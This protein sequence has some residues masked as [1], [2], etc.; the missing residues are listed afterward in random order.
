MISA[1]P[2]METKAALPV[3]PMPMEALR[4]TA[5]R[6]PLAILT[7]RLCPLTPGTYTLSGGAALPTGSRLVARNADV[8][9]QLLVETSSTVPSRAF[10]ISAVIKTLVFIA[11][12]S[13]TSFSN[14]TVYPQLETGLESTAFMAYKG[15]VIPLG[16]VELYGDAEVADV[17]DVVTGERDS[18][19]IRMEFDGTENGRMPH[20]VV[21]ASLVFRCLLR[22]TVIPK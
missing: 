11:V 19:W 1:I 17:L 22:Q 5:Q 13:G 7:F 2:D 21:G 9:S 8:A 4:L 20:R 10:T 18:R 6:R 16:G 15:E 14:I 3:W 12:P